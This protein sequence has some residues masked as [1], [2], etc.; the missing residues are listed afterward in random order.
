MNIS[1]W[2]TELHPTCVVVGTFNIYIFQPEWLAEVLEL[3]AGTHFEIET[4]LSRPGFKLSSKDFD[5]NWIVRPGRLQLEGVRPNPQL[6]DTLAKVIQKLPETPLYAIGKNFS[7]QVSDTSGLRTE[8]DDFLNFPNFPQGNVTRTLSGLSVEIG[9]QT[10][11]FVLMKKP[12]GGMEIAVN[13]HADA[14][15]LSHA[16]IIKELK[17]FNSDRERALEI[18]DNLWKRN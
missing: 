18:V 5:C 4:D 7:F 2:L 16:E 11:N 9:R 13:I 15:G 10:Y 3:K 14:A 6:G 1:D 12:N 17:Q 8:I